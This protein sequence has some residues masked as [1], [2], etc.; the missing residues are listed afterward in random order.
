[1]RSVVDLVNRSLDHSS[2][3]VRAKRERERERNTVDQL[4]DGQCEGEGQVGSAKQAITG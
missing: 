2:V 1:M 3:M 4:T